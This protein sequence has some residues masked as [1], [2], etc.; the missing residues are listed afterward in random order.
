MNGR[1]LGWEAATERLL[2]AAEV[3]AQEWPSHAAG[4]QH[5]A[6]WSVWNTITGGA[7]HPACSLHLTPSCTG[8]SHCSLTSSV[9]LSF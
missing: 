8:V 2:T 9:R 5:A 4:V 6:L 7:P 1:G 3:A